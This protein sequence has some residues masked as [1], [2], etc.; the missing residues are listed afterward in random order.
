MPANV[1]QTNSLSTISSSNSAISLNS[2]PPKPSINTTSKPSRNKP[3]LPSTSND[4]SSNRPTTR[5][6]NKRQIKS[7]ASN[8][9]I[10]RGSSSSSET[11]VIFY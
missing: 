11:E 9:E 10:L 1:H 7:K 3:A 4:V 2:L 6:S 5:N 8:F